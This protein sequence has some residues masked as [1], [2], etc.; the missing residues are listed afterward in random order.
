MATQGERPPDAERVEVQS[1]AQRESAAVAAAAAAIAAT[2]ALVEEIENTRGTWP[3][4]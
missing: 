1:R 2:A 3:N 4:A